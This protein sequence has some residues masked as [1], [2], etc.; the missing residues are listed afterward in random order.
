MDLFTIIPGIG[1]AL[2]AIRNWLALRKGADITPH[3]ILSYG[4]VRD[5]ADEPEVKNLYFPILFHNEGTKGGMI[6]KV[7]IFFQNG[8]K[9]KQ[10]PII[11]KIKLRELTDD[12]VNLGRQYADMV[13][14]EEKGYTIQIPTYPIAVAAGESIEAMFFC[15][16]YKEDNIIPLDKDIKCIIKIEYGK[17]KVNKIEFPFILTSEDFDGTDL[18]RWFKPHAGNMREQFPSDYK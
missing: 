10:L 9:I 12:Q 5:S 4:I 16:D 1:A 3:R 7:E 6:T 2:I 15:V 13:T 11:S 17:N 8:E 18:V 14:F